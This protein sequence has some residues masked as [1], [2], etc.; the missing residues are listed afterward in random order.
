MLTWATNRRRRS[1]R[2]RVSGR[3]LVSDSVK[4]KAATRACVADGARQRL[5]SCQ[6]ELGLAGLRPG[7]RTPNIANDAKPL[8]P[9]FSRFGPTSGRRVRGSARQR[10][11]KSVEGARDSAPLH[12]PVWRLPALLFPPE[13]GPRRR[14]LAR[15]VR[16]S[17]LAPRGAPR[18][19]IVGIGFLFVILRKP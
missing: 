8:I 1:R 16:A 10:V 18:G 14:L 17:S 15:R 7:A 2:R 6:R 13:R 4:S 3:Q 5:V 11:S 12:S 19:S 9:D